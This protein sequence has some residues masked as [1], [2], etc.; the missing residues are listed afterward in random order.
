MLTRSEN[1]PPGIG[2]DEVKGFLRYLAAQ[3]HPQEIHFLWR[4]CLPDPDDDLVLELAFAT[5][6]THM[7]NHD[8]RDF[9]ARTN[10]V[11]PP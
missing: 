7:V 11:S 9:L 5:G 6:A 2:P 3:A 8:V 1:F 10:W 4:P